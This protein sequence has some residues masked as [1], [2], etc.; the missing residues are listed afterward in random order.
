MKNFD[1]GKK[2]KDLRN[3]KGL[4]QEQLAEQ[5][6]L[7]LRTIQRIENGETE[8]RGDTLK[9][10]ASALSV[11]PEDLTEITG[12]PA[13]ENIGDDSH[14]FLALLNLSALSFILFPLLGIAVPLALWLS[15][16]KK[17]LNIDQHC[18]RII[19]FQISWCLLIAAMLIVLFN[20]DAFHISHN[21]LGFGVPELI[22]LGIAGM[23]FFNFVYIIF[24]SILVMNTRQIIYQPTVPFLR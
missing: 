8:A 24:N 11:L 15:N 14:G 6:Q 4:S 12:E 3:R 22:I 21:Y 19:N 13:R 7:S 17:V 16:R 20:P 2:I 23:Y 1:L 18:K 10:L 5:A 9:R